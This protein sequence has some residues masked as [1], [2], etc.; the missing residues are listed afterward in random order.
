MHLCW[1]L[2]CDGR[3]ARNLSKRFL[4]DNSQDETKKQ[5]LLLKGIF[6]GVV[7]KIVPDKIVVQIFAGNTFE[8]TH[9]LL[10]LTVIVV[11]VLDMI[12]P[13]LGFAGLYLNQIDVIR[14]AESAIGIHLVCDHGATGFNSPIVDFVQIF[15]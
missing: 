11:D 9:K 7:N 14:F 4:E 3:S 1:E 13:L 5:L 15:G 10:Q 12:D 8:P 2:R 6:F